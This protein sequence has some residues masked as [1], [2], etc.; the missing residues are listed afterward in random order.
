M[1]DN[2]LTKAYDD[3]MEHLYEAMDGTLHSVADALDAAKEKTSALGGHT[4]EEINRIADALMR[5]VEHIATSPAPEAENE[6]LSEWLKFDIELLENFALDAFMS[7]AD[8][9]RVKLAALEMDAKQ[10]HPYASGDVTAPGTLTCDGC[11]KQI[12]FKSTSVIPECPACKGTA[13]TRC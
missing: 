6:S 12:A 8:K 11:G 13:F 1:G 2:K 5:D 9:T 4:Q 3:L 10:Y 7:I